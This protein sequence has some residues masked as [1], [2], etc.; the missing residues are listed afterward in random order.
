MQSKSERQYVSLNSP[1]TVSGCNAT[2]RRPD[3]KSRPMK[4]NVSS[5][6]V[7]CPR[8]IGIVVCAQ[9]ELNRSLYG[10]EV[11]IYGS[12]LDLVWRAEC[13]APSGLGS[14]AVASRRPRSP[15]A[16]ISVIIA[17]RNPSLIPAI[18]LVRLSEHST[19][20]SCVEG[21]KGIRIVR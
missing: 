15:L 5:P 14:A 11:A 19:H 7:W 10:L 3:K 13:V 21:F 2:R 1:G 18:D 12:N 4:Q 6:T 8:P 9:A 17:V 20:S 16:V